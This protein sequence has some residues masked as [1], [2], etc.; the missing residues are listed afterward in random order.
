MRISTR[1]RGTRKL[2]FRRLERPYRPGTKIVVSATKLGF[3]GKQQ[4]WTIR[5]RRSPLHREQCLYPRCDSGDRPPGVMRVPGAALL[6]TAGCAALFG[7]SFAAA[8]SA[9]DEDRSAAPTRAKSAPVG[10]SP[11]PCWRSDQTLRGCPACA[12][13]LP[14]S[15]WRPR[16]RRRPQPRPRRRPGPGP[17]RL[18]AAGAGIAVGGSLAAPAPL[19]APAPAPSRPS[20]LPAGVGAATRSRLL[21]LRRMIGSQ[22]ASRPQHRN[23]TEVGAMIDGYRVERVISIRPACSWRPRLATGDA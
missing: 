17:L 14:R 18:P 7:G 12:S 16:G 8:R 3:M 9:S 21:R 20:S 22:Q 13:R 15:W 10:S 2:R 4:T 23:P 5:R 1:G 6:V 11:S 19:S